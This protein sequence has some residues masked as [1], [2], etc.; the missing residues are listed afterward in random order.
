M[1]SSRLTPRIEPG[2][3]KGKERGALH[4]KG[5]WQSRGQ[6]SAPL[7]RGGNE[8]R[9]Q[10]RSGA[11]SKDAVTRGVSHAKV[12]EAAGPVV[13]RQAT[14]VPRYLRARA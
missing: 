2:E 4:L 11:R 5:R 8:Q 10:D 6:N 1:A 12:R 14:G 7:G 3:G 13:V 9:A